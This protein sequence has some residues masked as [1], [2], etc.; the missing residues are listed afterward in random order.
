MRR[1]V[2]WGGAAMVSGSSLAVTAAVQRRISRM[3]LSATPSKTRLVFD[4]DGP[5]Q[6]S[7]FALDNP[8]RLVI[9]VED[10]RFAGGSPDASA[11][12]LIRG[13]R[14]GKRHGDDLRVVLDL[15]RRV[16]AQRASC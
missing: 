16:R 9:D 13:I 11:S 3:R 5:V 1:L 10:T 6:H 2:T 12:S 4:L 7:L 15:Q 14:K 8:A